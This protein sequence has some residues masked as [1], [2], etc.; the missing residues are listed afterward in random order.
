MNNKYHALDPWARNIEAFLRRGM[1][2]VGKYIPPGSDLYVL[3]FDKPTGEDAYASGLHSGISGIWA[4]HQ[5]G[6]V[7]SLAALK[8]A[9]AN[10]QNG[11]AQLSSDALGVLRGNSVVGILHDDRYL[12]TLMSSLEE[13]N[14]NSSRRKPKINDWLVFGLQGETQRISRIGKNMERVEERTEEYG[15]EL[16]DWVS[17]LG[18]NNEELLFIGTQPIATHFAQYVSNEIEGSGVYL[19]G[20]NNREESVD[21]E[22]LEG[23]NIVII[24]SIWLPECQKQLV[25]AKEKLGNAKPKNVFYSAEYGP[26]MNDLVNHVLHATDQ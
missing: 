12:D 1:T 13:A 10:F 23:K 26:I 21:A 14:K 7:V 20:Q 25:A 24:D 8:A 15:Q 19:V 11:N 22:K 17:G 6:G 2:Y 16:V 5:K 18:F 3:S 4:N 9:A